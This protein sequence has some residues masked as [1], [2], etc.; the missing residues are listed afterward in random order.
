MVTLDID[1]GKKYPQFRAGAEML[2]QAFTKGETP[3]RVP[4]YAQ[5]HEFSLARYGLTC[6]EFYQ[7]PEL[8]V[9]CQLETCAE[10]GIDVPTVDWDC[11]NI[12]AEAVGQVVVFD[13]E[14]MPDV[15]REQ[16]FIA[17]TSDIDRIVTPDFENA[18]RC[19]DIV[20][21]MEMTATKT[22]IPPSIVFCGPFSFAANVRGIEALIF[23]ILD[24]PRF[25]NELFEKTVD[26]VIGPWINYLVG[27]FP[28][29]AG[30][31]GADATASVPIISPGM[32]EEWVIPYIKRLRDVTRDDV[33]IP[34]WVGEA[35]L[36]DPE[37]YVDMKLEVTQHF[38]EG[39]DPDVESLGPEFYVDYAAR[40]DVPLVLGVG[41][42]FLALA[43]PRDVYDRVQRY[44]RAGMEHDRFALYLCN[45]G[46][47]T[48][49]ANVR[50]ALDAAKTHGEY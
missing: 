36:K 33:S 13:E 17:D 34:N 46:A 7:D 44:V 49:D 28:D 10:Y 42:S 47:T 35:S 9:H 1:I 23:D 27:V 19:Q 26:E 48:P 31:A 37:S 15:D 22:G 45:L 8:M 16:P 6:R 30:I 25:A 43:E 21:L 11:Y 12:E 29:V 50:A 39:Q 40:H 20:R 14:N 4:V 5:H 38:I 32:A 2:A 41:A 18:G 24:S 3:E